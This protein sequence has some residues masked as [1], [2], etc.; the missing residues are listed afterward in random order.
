[1]AATPG[2]IVLL[3]ALGGVTCVDRKHDATV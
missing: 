2:W 1:M 3:R